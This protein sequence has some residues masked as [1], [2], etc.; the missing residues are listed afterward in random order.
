MNKEL[1]TILTQ[2]KKVAKEND[3][4][5]DKVTK[6]M[7]LSDSDVT[8][9][10]LRKFGGLSSIL[11]ANFPVE[12]KSLGTIQS[13]KETQSYISKL[14][15]LLGNK[16]KFE[17]EV[18]EIFTEKLKPLPPIKLK[19]VKKQKTKQKRDIVMMLNDTHFG[20]KVESDEVNGLNSYDW[21]EACRRVAMVLQE[22]IEFKPHT[23]NEVETVHLV[24]AGDLTS[25]IIHGLNTKGIDLYV[26]Q[27]NG[28]VHILTHVISHLLANFKQ[29]KVHGISGNHDDSIHKREHGNRVI[30]EKYDSY[31][32]TC[33]YSLSAIFNLNNRVEFNFPKTPYAFANLAGGRAMIAHGDVIF[34]RA[35][36]NPGTTI[37]VKSLSEEIRKFNAGEIARGKDPVKLVLFGHTHSFAH[38]ITQDGVEVYNAPSLSGVDGY[39][40]SLNI[41]TN[42][43]GQLVFEST[44]DFILGDHR[45]IR[46]NKAD[47]NNEL[48][49][50]IPTFERDLKWRKQ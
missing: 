2:I 44:K 46:V 5:P 21:K 24:L 19:N 37:N 25:G 34:S 13:L 41:N 7:L 39:A 28:T 31:V 12:G 50:L 29:V 4:S 30:T 18:K 42:F 45:L 36:G 33:F 27:L 20:L 38:F 3:I 23:K 9:W 35:L 49:K 47:N 17:E 40:H 16:E 22:T 48:D 1:Q 6:T 43:V 8:D 15:K 10:T 11:K 14:E 26:H 32:N